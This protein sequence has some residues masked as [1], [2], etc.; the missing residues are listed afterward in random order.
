M[1]GL[2]CT[3]V[4]FATIANAFAAPVLSSI[5]TAGKEDVL[6]AQDDFVALRIDETTHA[7]ALW[8]MARTTTKWK[9]VERAP[10]KIVK[11]IACEGRWVALVEG[12][13]VAI[14][15]SR[16]HGVTWQAHT[17]PPLA[18]ALRDVQLAVDAR[19]R[20]LVGDHASLYASNAAGVI[21][22][23][24]PIASWTVD[25][26]PRGWFSST[27]PRRDLWITSNKR[28]LRWDVDRGQLRVTALVPERSAVQELADR[29]IAGGLEVDLSGAALTT[30]PFPYRFPV[31]SPYA[32]DTLLVWKAQDD[33]DGRTLYELPRGGEP[34][35]R[36]KLPAEQI[37]EAWKTVVTRDR[38]FIA[39]KDDQLKARAAGYILD[40]KNHAEKIAAPDGK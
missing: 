5:P 27:A 8:V 12:P 1:R 15:D 19:G 20:I 38:V 28:L 14:Y 10:E 25:G 16:D 32:N 3:I 2:L 18:S 34:K 31:V 9:R 4:T 33:D 21:E 6:G 11:L 26:Y 24:A 7:S 40:V 39:V 36:W 30:K 37:N 35:V 23:V 22:F 29:F 17:L 13:P